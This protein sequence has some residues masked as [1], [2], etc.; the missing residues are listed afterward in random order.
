[1]AG[2]PG[3]NRAWNK[4]PVEEHIRRGTYRQDRHGPWPVP[5][6]ASRIDAWEPTADDL[7]TLGPAGRRFLTQM[8]ER[9]ESSLVQGTLLLEAAHV[10]DDLA[11]WRP[12]A[13]SDAQAARLCLAQVKTLAALLAQLQAS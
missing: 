12:L 9:F 13:P 10:V 5:D 6:P 2:R 3:R 11:T 1:M 7:A 4:L 8:H